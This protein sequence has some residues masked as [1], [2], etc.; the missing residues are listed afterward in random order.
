M[1]SRLDWVHKV[2]PLAKGDVRTRRWSLCGP[3]ATAKFGTEQP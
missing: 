1:H 2:G 3:G